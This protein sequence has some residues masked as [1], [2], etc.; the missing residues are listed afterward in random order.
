MPSTTAARTPLLALLCLAAALLLPPVADAK[1]DQLDRAKAL[2]AKLDRARTFDQRRAALLKTFR[3]LGVRQVFH[4]IRIRPGKPLWFGVGPDRDDGRPPALV[5]GLPGNPLS[6]L[7]NF[8]NF[9]AALHDATG[10][11]VPER[12]YPMIRTIDGCTAYL[13][14]HVAT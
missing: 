5:F 14:T 13:A 1:P 12:D 6:G 3:A 2:A 7:V 9:V 11:D 8:L 4:K 10:V